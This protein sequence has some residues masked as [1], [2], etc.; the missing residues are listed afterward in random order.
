MPMGFCAIIG[1]TMTLVGASPTILLND[2]HDSGQVHSTSR[3]RR[4]RSRYHRH[5]YN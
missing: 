2:L 5:A 1:G 3:E 4:G